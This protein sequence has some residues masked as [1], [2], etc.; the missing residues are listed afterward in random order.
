MQVWKQTCLTLSK[1]EGLPKDML[2]P[3]TPQHLLLDSPLPFIEVRSSSI[4]CNT[5]ISCPNQGNITGPKKHHINQSHLWGQTPQARTMSFNFFFLINHSVF[6]LLH[7]STFMVAFCSAVEFSFLFLSF[8]FPSSF[9]FHHCVCVCDF[10]MILFL[11]YLTAFLIALYWLKLFLNICKSFSYMSVYLCFSIF[12][13]L[14]L[15]PSFPPFSSLF[16]FS[17]SKLN[18]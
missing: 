11:I 1:P 14:S 7:I 16:L 15:L 12:Y 9:L 6:F 2:N 13:F 5:G 17:P 4:N 18:C 10:F 8:F 3:Q